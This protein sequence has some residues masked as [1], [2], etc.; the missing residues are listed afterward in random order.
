M[1][2]FFVCMSKPLSSIT[3]S[4]SPLPRC[5][6]YTVLLA[7][8]VLPGR[9]KLPKA[10]PLKIT[11]LCY[12]IATMRQFATA[13]IIVLPHAEE[14]RHFY[15]VSHDDL[16]TTLNTPDIHDGLSDGRYT[17][18]KAFPDHRLYVYYYI[19]LPLQGGRDEAYAIIDFI[20]Y[21][22]KEDTPLPEG[23]KTADKDLHCFECGGVIAKN[24]HYLRKDWQKRHYPACPPTVYA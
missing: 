1:K 14:Y 7:Q 9:L 23:L 21:T 2:V 17:N 4:T 12:T 18:E 5:F 6:S 19:T 8:D 20:G 15:G 22:P 13:H 10:H 24:T 11:S 16:L 3:H